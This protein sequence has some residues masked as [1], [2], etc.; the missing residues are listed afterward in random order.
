[1]LIYDQSSIYIN[2]TQIRLYTIYSHS[3]RGA[4]ALLSDY[5]AAVSETAGVLAESQ[6]SGHI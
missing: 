4:I 5:A 6:L 1:M 2:I 3:T